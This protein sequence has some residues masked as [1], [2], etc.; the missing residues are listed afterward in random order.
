MLSRD[1][2]VAEVSQIILELQR[3][4]DQS[5][6]ISSED[7]SPALTSLKTRIGA[8]RVVLFKKLEPD[9]ATDEEDSKIRRRS[10]ELGVYDAMNIIAGELSRVEAR[11]LALLDKHDDKD[12]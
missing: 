7:I 2:L 12:E 8:L 3:L 6:S 10:A 5:S 9:F 4:T 11:I 1:D